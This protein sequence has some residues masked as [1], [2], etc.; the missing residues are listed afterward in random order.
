MM[1]SLSHSCEV[2]VGVAATNPASAIAVN[3]AARRVARRSCGDE[4]QEKVSV[5]I[6]AE[7][8]QSGRGEAKANECCGVAARSSA[9]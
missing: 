5:A 9:T 1:S 8:M 4:G 6:E 3:C 2:F 7:Q